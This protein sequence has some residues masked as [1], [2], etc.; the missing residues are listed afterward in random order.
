MILVIFE[1]RPYLQEKS[2]VWAQPKS[3]II[4]DPKL[5]HLFSKTSKKS[6]NLGTFTQKVIKVTQF[7]N[8]NITQRHSRSDY[9]CDCTLLGT[10]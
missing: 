7:R 6:D 5:S 9:L 8:P 4:Q 1:N 10:L 3:T 2:G